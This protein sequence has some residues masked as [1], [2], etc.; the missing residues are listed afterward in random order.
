MRK[1]FTQFFSLEHYS[2]TFSVLTTTSLLHCASNLK[3]LRL[4]VLNRAHLPLLVDSKHAGLLHQE[5]L[6]V[7]LLKFE[8]ILQRVARRSFKLNDALIVVQLA[9]VIHD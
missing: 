6:H 8:V 7:I 3:L 9:M 4:I 2:F 1:K 5:H